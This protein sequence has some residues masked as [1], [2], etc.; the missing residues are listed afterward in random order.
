[1][2]ALEIIVT[3]TGLVETGLF[4]ALLY[5]AQNPAPEAKYPHFVVKS[6]KFYRSRRHTN[7]TW[8]IG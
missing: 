2:N 7:G 3:L 6:K 4:F 1:M 5:R 8:E